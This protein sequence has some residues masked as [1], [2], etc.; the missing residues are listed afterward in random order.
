MQFQAFGAFSV[1]HFVLLSLKGDSGGPL[2]SKQNGRWILGGVVSFGQGCALADF[3]GVYAR[4]SEYQAW[5]NG[6]ITTEQPG[7]F[8]FSSTGT[9]TDLSVTCDGLPPVP[10]PTVPREWLL[11]SFLSVYI[12]HL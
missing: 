12:F 1:T 7:F 10:T 6:Q 3:P 5:I 11:V 8:T 2:V 9:D 4:V